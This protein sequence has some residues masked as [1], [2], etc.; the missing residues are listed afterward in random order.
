MEVIQASVL[1]PLV[2]RPG[3][4]GVPSSIQ[5]VDDR[6]VRKQPTRISFLA[7]AALLLLTGCSL[8]AREVPAGEPFDLLPGERVSVQ[9]AGL[10]IELGTVGQ[11]WTMDGAEIPFA[12]VS[13]VRG[14]RRR[15]QEMETGEVW[16]LDSTSVHLRAADPF[17]EN[18]CSFEV[19]T[20]L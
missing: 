6:T 2:L 19:T 7:T 18:R 20:D 14:F 10:I 17:G 13:V 16:Q 15:T 11:A 8:F 9:G 1:R 12:E 4:Y 3:R 5:K